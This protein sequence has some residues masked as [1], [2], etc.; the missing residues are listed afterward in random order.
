[1]YVDTHL[2]N[3]KNKYLHFLERQV[4]S[5]AKTAIPSSWSCSSRDKKK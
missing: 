4:I 5:Y 1:M 2:I 3:N